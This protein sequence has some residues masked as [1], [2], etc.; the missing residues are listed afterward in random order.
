MTQLETLSSNPRVTIRRPGAPAPGGRCVVYWMQR[1]QRALDNPAL[2]VAV[3]AA[4]ALH[5]PVVIFFAPV[6]FYPRANLRHY[7]FLAQGIADIADRARKRCIG[8]VLR[9]YPQHS[10]LKFCDEVKASIVIGD[11][12]PVREPRHWRELAAKKLSV[13]LWTVDADVIIPSKLLQKEQYAARIIRPRLQQHLQQFQAT[14]RNPAAKV[15][16]HAPRGLAALPDDSCLDI[17]E[18]WNHL[19]RSVQP[20]DSFR[21]G[22]TEALNLLDQ[23]VKHKLAT[24]PEN[25]GKPELDGTSRLSPYL[26]FGHIGPH[27][28]MHAVL[29]SK[30]PQAAKDDYINQFL[31]W[32]ELAINFV[33]FNPV[34][35]SIECAPDW[36]HKTLAAHAHDPRP[37]LYTRDQFE[38]AQTHDELWNAAQLQMLHA[39]WMHNYMRMYWA[40]KILEWSPSPA[41]AWQ[42][43]LYLNDKYFL[44]GRDPDGYAGVAWAMGGKFDRPWFERPI[45]GTIRWMSGDAARKK[46]DAAKYIAQMNALAGKLAASPQSR[47]F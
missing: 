10:L 15:E 20:A 22:T 9:T 41:V 29:K 40:K 39:G 16:W 33:H 46:F 24:Y 5:Q 35:D 4:N 14:S 18:G 38:S 2:D 32:R 13:P 36:A 44:D 43:A 11:E 12:N 42:T 34:Y 21:G 47:L 8:F 27:T 6:P 23:F 25:H 7:T 45:F 17:T 37:I 19:D 1:T 28:V 26:H 3:D 31:T 30:A